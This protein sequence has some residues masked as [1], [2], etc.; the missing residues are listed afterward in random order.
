MPCYEVLWQCVERLPQQQGVDMN[1]WR[2]LILFIIRT[3]ENKKGAWL[4]SKARMILNGE[5]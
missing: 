4:Y 1:C 2:I 5:I 3:A